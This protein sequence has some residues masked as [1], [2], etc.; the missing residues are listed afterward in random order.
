M[1]AVNYQYLSL[2]SD[3]NKIPWTFWLLLETTFPDQEISKKPK[4][5]EYK[6]LHSLSTV[7]VLTT[8]VSEGSRVLTHISAKFVGDPITNENVI[9]NKMIKTTNQ[10]EKQMF[11][12]KTPQIIKQD[13]KTIPTPINH[14]KLESFL[15]GYDK[16][17]SQ[18][19]VDGFNN[20]SSFQG[21]H[22][23]QHCFKSN[24]VKHKTSFLMDKN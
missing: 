2:F 14:S 13:K 7:T 8:N 24:S 6:G 5:A 10:V 12:P 16:L 3:R 19:L 23:F 4:I 17:E 9:Q 22:K 21:E 18:F 15:K 1:I 11:R 20:G